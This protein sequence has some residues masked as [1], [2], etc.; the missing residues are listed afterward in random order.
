MKSRVDRMAPDTEVRAEFAPC[1]HLCIV[2]VA[3]CALLPFLF[4]RFP[5]QASQW[6][7]RYP[8]GIGGIGLPGHFVSNE[9][10]VIDAMMEILILVFG[11][12]TY[13]AR[14]LEK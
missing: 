2:L 8:I 7:K 5:V 4:S 13:R 10:L 1:P 11:S 6:Q 14:K 3:P 9:G 12:Y